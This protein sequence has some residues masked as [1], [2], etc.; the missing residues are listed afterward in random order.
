MPGALALALA[1]TCALTCLSCAM[2]T[3]FS[4]LLICRCCAS[5]PTWLYVVVY[6]VPEAGLIGLK[7]GLI[8]QDSLSSKQGWLIDRWWAI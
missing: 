8:E 5:V 1:P 2:P 7:A 4:D 3:R 6:A